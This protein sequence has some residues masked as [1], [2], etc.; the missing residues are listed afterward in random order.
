MSIVEY[1]FQEFTDRDM[2]EI[3]LKDTIPDFGYI[4]CTKRRPFFDFCVK[5]RFLALRR[6]TTSE[7]YKDTSLHSVLIDF[8]F[9]GMLDY[10]PKPIIFVTD[11]LIVVQ[12]S[13]KMHNLRENH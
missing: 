10:R 5:H 4:A 7:F 2:F 11:H 13:F 3:K 12:P 8:R 1:N 9:S 6:K